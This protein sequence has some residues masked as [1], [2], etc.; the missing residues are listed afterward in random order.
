MAMAGTI[1]ENLPGRG[2][3]TELDSRPPATPRL[4]FVEGQPVHYLR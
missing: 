1:R 4:A 2:G 3:G